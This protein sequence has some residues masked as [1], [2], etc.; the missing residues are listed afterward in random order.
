MFVYGDMCF[1]NNENKLN[2]LIHHVIISNLKSLLYCGDIVF[3]NV[4]KVGEIEAL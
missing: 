3:S 1:I 4:E 2:M